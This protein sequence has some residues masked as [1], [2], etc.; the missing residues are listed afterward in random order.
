MQL[1]ADHLSN[2][3]GCY[4]WCS[5]HDHEPWYII[6]ITIFTPFSSYTY[7]EYF[8]EWP[9]SVSTSRRIL[10]QIAAT[11]PTT[12]NW[13]GSKARALIQRLVFTIYKLADGGHEGNFLGSLWHA[14]LIEAPLSLGPLSDKLE[15]EDDCSFVFLSASGCNRMG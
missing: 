7:N 5:P 2:E 12:R 14:C 3:Y 6:I 4:V 11:V 1:S 9:L 8:Q 13:L 15:S 10:T